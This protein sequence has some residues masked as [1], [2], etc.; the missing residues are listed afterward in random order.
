MRFLSALKESW[1]L[2]YMELWTKQLM[3]YLHCKPPILN[4]TCRIVWEWKTLLTNRLCTF[5]SINQLYGE[6]SNLTRFYHNT[7]HLCQIY[8]VF[9][10]WNPCH[11]QSSLPLT[12][13]PVPRPMCMDC[14]CSPMPHAVTVFVFRAVRPFEHFGGR[15]NIRGLSHLLMSV[16]PSRVALGWVFESLKTQVSNFNS[17]GH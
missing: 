3:F 9:L 12:S 15:S 14:L 6:K 16:V 11:S 13:I 4:L 7:R 17:I 5:A 8:G 10:I 1:L 2:I